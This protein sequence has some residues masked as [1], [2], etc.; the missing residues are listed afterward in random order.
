MAYNRLTRKTKSGR[1]QLSLYDEL[2]DFL[3]QVDEN[4]YKSKEEALDKAADFFL[5]QVT[6]ASPVSDRNEKYL[7]NTARVKESWER[8][9]KEYTNV[10]YIYNTALTP[11][12]IPVAN[13]VEFSKNGTPFIRPCFEQNKAEIVNI[14]IGGIKP[15]E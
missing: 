4:V 12:R 3:E 10:R 2:H 5:Q 15:N 6:A 13:L 1:H 9:S 14:I 11:K 7:Y 8:N